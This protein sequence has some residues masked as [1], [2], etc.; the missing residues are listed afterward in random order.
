MLVLDIA[1]A[2]RLLQYRFS[3]GRSEGEV[4]SDY[5][6]TGTAPFIPAATRARA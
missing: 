1:R 4:E 3:V 2:I 6:F 5:V